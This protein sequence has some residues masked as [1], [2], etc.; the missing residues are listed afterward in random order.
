MAELESEEVDLCG[1]WLVQKDRSVI[2][3]ATEQR[4]QWL[5]TEKLERIAMIRQVGR[6]F[7]ETREMVGFGS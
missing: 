1:N 7:I 4:I 5:T 6:L 3:D 2:G